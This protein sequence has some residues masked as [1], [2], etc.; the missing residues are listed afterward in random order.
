ME[1]C[2]IAA[3][4]ALSC[5]LL[6]FSALADGFYVG[7]EAGQGRTQ[8]DTIN[9]G[10]TA[11]QSFLLDTSSD[12]KDTA[13]GL[14]GGYTFAK[15]F[16]VEL[17]Y[18]DLGEISF[19]EVRA[20]PPLVPFPLPPAAGLI[21]SV[22]V[23]GG[24]LNPALFGVGLP[25]QRQTLT[26]KSKALSLAVAGRYEIAGGFSILGRAG[27]ATHQTKSSVGFALDG[28]PVRVI[29][30]EDKASSGA[31]VL[32]I[33]AE[34]A[35]HSNWAARVQAQ[36]HFLLEEE[37]IYPVDRGDVTTLTAGIEFRF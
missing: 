29:G 10:F 32:G 27:L 19:T 15:H 25:I 31:A 22:S 37:E 26:L 13:A 23:P 9:R 6:S 14:Y 8:L 4:F 11:T 30:G 3:A 35:F 1:R 5:G 16:G 21:T 24:A 34:W 7:I 2:R 12:R 28:V 33:G 17:A 36:R 20:I 18:A